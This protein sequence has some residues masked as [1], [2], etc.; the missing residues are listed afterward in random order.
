MRAWIKLGGQGHL[1]ARNKY[2]TGHLYRA[3][4]LLCQQSIISLALAAGVVFAQ[5]PGASYG[6]NPTPNSHQTPAIRLLLTFDD[7]PSTRTSSSPTDQ[8]LNVLAHNSV[9]EGIKAVFFSQTRLYDIHSGALTRKLLQREAEEGHVLG[10]HSGTLKHHSD[11]RGLD[12]LELEG[13]LTDTKVILQEIT[14]ITPLLVRP[15]YWAFNDRTQRAYAAFDLH[16]LLTDVSVSDGKSWGYR[17]NPRRRSVLREQMHAVHKRI[18]AGQIPIVDG[19]LPVIVTFHDTNTWTAKHMEEY[20]E[21]LVSSAIEAGIVLDSQP[22]YTDRDQ[23]EQAG[24]QRSLQEH[25]PISLVPSRWRGYK[26][27]CLWPFCISERYNL[28]SI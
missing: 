27:L 16:M 18:A 14:G 23:L 9:Q 6:S 15:P 11:H 12:N 5:A 8:I 22:F 3:L 7:G 13:F 4:K 24:L 25:N 21:L 2:L 17:A 19:L 1:E 20:L 26:S 10:V 28:L